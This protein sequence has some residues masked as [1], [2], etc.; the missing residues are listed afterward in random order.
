M[1]QYF[2]LIYLLQKMSKRLN[3]KLTKAVL[4]GSI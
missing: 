2:L 1:I 3:L 4:H